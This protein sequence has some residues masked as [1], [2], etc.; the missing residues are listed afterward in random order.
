MILGYR[1]IDDDPNIEGLPYQG[2]FK[3]NR[4]QN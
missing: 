4:L 1:V 3:D 2:E